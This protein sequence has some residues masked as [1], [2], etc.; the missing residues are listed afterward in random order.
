MSGPRHPGTEGNDLWPADVKFPDPDGGDGRLSLVNDVA[1]EFS[2]LAISNTQPADMPDGGLWVNLSADATAVDRL[3]TYDASTDAFIPIQA[4]ST[5]VQDSEPAH[6]KGLI[7]FDSS[8]EHGFDMYFSDG[9]TWYFLQFIPE[10]PDM[11][12]DDFSHNDLSEFYGGDLGGF[13]I[14]DSETYE[15]DFALRKDTTSISGYIAASL[16]GDGLDYYPEPGV[17]IKCY[18]YAREFGGIKIY[19]TIDKKSRDDQSGYAVRIDGTNLE[20]RRLDDGSR[21][22]I[23]DTS[24]DPPEDEWLRLE[25]IHDKN[26]DFKVDLIQDSDGHTIGDITATDDEYITDGEYDFRG[27]A[28]EDSVSETDITIDNIRTLID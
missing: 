5:V 26:G 19:R 7:W 18:I 17:P 14:D 3:S 10:I 20:L 15:G 21:T 16:E 11:V 6:S 25:W 28:V 1:A 9:E 23:E 27:F 13:Y 8:P 22:T 12:V 24:I 2:G 4:D